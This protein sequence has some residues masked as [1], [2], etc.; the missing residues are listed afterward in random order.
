M[1]AMIN[2]MQHSIAGDQLAFGLGL[3]QSAKFRKEANMGFKMRKTTYVDF[4]IDRSKL[5][6]LSKA[7]EIIGMSLP[8]VIRAIERGH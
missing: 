2:L 4:D 3:I 8:G 5:V 1:Q 7:A 6:S